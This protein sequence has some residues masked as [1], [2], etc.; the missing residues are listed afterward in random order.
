MY[1]IATFEKT[2]FL[3]LALTELESKGLEREDI[4][5][6]PLEKR[7]RT[8]QLMDTIHHADGHSVL[9]LAAI[10]GTVFMLLGTIYGFVLR[11]GPILWGLIGAIIG[12]LTGFLIKYAIVRK[13]TNPTPGNITSEVVV[14][15]SCP[16]RDGEWVEHVLW[17]NRALGVSK[18][19]FSL[20]PAVK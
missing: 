9:D 15:V 13:Q 17:E 16:D 12:V 3:E 8:L 2:V 14:M 4:L 20:S 19:S 6:V 1:V 7:R 11:W 10:L 5:A 18:I